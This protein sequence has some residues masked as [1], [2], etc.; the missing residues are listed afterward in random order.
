MM[1]E[2]ARKDALARIARA[3]VVGAG[4]AGFPC[5]V[6]LDV[7]VDTVMA[8]GAECEPLLGCDVAA[9]EAWLPDFLSG[10]EAACDLTGA[11]RGI[12]GMKEKH[13]ELCDTIDSALASHPRLSLLRMGNYYPAGDEVILIEVG[14]GRVVP[15]GGLP[16]DVGVV[17]QN[18]YTLINLARAL[19]GEAVTRRLVTVAGEVQ[20]PQTRM[21]SVGTRIGDLLEAAGGASC[22]DPVLL[23]GGPMMGKVS[24]DLDTPITKTLGGIIVLPRDHRLIA[25]R[26]ASPSR[27][28]ARARS[29]CCQ[30]NYCTDLC[31]RFLVG[32]D[33]KPH[34]MMRELTTARDKGFPPSTMA[35]LCTECGL[36]GL[37]SC[38][39]GIMPNAVNAE[40]KRILREAGVRPDRHAAP[41]AARETQ[42]GRKVPTGRLAGRID[43][44]RY[45]APHE[46]GEEGHFPVDLEVLRV[47][48][49]AIPLR[50]HAGSPATPCVAVGDHVAAG[51]AVGTM[52]GS[53]GSPPPLGADVHCDLPGRVIAVGDSVIV[54]VDS[55]E[56][57]R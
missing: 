18:V 49:L 22:E 28:A 35:Y 50:Q 14:T 31:P 42:A 6:K 10:L 16:K 26:L 17:V 37:Y 40:A 54:E 19:R 3:G 12:I 20:R 15:E 33:M 36:C 52:R 55:T 53:S 47:R 11:S 25:A 13:H 34:V 43:V 32:H 27:Q 30:C 21:V 7:R 4:G 1:D 29:A 41:A 24:E 45:M 44:L 57:A 38:A 5:H 48:R 46:P 8:N 2:A 9:M 23:L 56:A 51:Q 39:Q